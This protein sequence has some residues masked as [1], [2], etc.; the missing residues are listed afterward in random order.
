MT[1]ATDPIRARGRFLLGS[2]IS[3]ATAA[4]LTNPRNDTN[5]SAVVDRTAPPPSGKNGARLA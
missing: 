5:T 4:I 1:S 3:S 2:L